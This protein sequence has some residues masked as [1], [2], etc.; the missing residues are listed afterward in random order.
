MNKKILIQ[1]GAGL[2]LALLLN[3]PGFSQIV[4]SEWIAGTGTRGWDIVNDMTCDRTGNIYITGSFTDTVVKSK[5]RHSASN[6]SHTMYVAKFDTNG[7]TIWKKNILNQGS[8]FGGL[9]G[10]GQHDELILAGGEV[11]SNKKAGVKPGRSGFF[12]S[13]LS[14]NGS[15]K[16]TQNFCGSN[17]DYLTSMV[18][19]TMGAEILITGYFH[20]TLIIGKKTLISGGMTD[21]VFLRFDLNGNLKSTHVIGGK[22][23]D[24]INCIATDS[25]GNR[26]VAGVFQRKIQFENKTTFELNNHQEHGLFLAKYN[27]EGDI[28]ATKQLATGK[29]IM[30]H[31]IADMN[32]HIIIAGSFSDNL[33]IGNK[34]L[35]SH[36]SDDVFLMFL[37]QKLQI[38][39]YKQIGGTKKDR[40]SKII[41]VG[42]EIVLSG[43]FSSSIKI[44]DKKLTASG[45]GSDV[46]I[47][48]TDIS[49]NLR[50]MRSAGGEADDYPTCMIAAP[51]DYIY[52]AGSF[53]EK[54]NMNGKT[55]Q[56]VGEE[57]V[58]IGRLENCH[59]LSPA[60]HKPEYLCE[61]NLIHLD[62]GSGFISYNWANGQSH[63]RTF[64]I[65]QGGRYPFVLIA[66]N[67]CVI[68]DTIPVI[69]VPQPV[70]NLGNDTT[71][72]DTSRILL[73]AGGNF[74]TYSWNN[75]TTKSENL[76]K[77]VELHEGPNHVNVI[78]T[79]DKGCTGNNGVVITMI[80]TMANH[81][82]ELISESCIIFPNPTRDLVT[83]YFTMSFKSLVLTVYDPMGKELMTHSASG[84]VKN[85]PLEF[86]LGTLAKGLYSLY[87][88]TDRGI[89]TKKIVLQ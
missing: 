51:N 44:D 16:W 58:F 25:L 23:E 48:A 19:D 86:N 65:D 4:F 62:A 14:L 64:N 21:G 29:K 46:F 43:S 83:V 67:G 8:G 85:V 37:D 7:K 2:V 20:D 40:A 80:R 45:I 81:A 33:I 42:D 47:I 35:S 63:E 11:I 55:L 66:T 77:G 84:Y 31:S 5:I 24:K 70:V 1:G 72:A 56:S 32:D 73:H 53:R 12:I 71:I 59:L 30:V 74:A 78:V 41:I 75:G 89:A 54:F 36:G 15:V 28:I 79:N 39:W 10:R 88:K 60:F 69:D 68:Y 34:I 27:Y 26:Y 17:L 3:V 6:N 82:S 61:R 9:I 87:I 13:S 50:W 76:I 38:Q 18:V 57:D 52:L 49:G 22:G